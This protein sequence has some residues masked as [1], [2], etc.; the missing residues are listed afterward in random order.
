MCKSIIQLAEGEHHSIVESQKNKQNV[1]ETETS[2]PLMW[3]RS[4]GRDLSSLS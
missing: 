4:D 2:N 3:I 1:Q